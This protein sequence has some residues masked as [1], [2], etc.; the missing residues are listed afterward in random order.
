[1]IYSL[2]WHLQCLK[3]KFLYNL[4]NFK[5]FW[6]SL[7]W[8]L[9]WIIRGL[10]VKFD[11]LYDH[12]RDDPEF[13]DVTLVW[14]K[15][16]QF[17]A[18]HFSILFSKVSQPNP[19]IYLRGQYFFQILWFQMYWITWKICLVKFRCYIFWL[20]DGQSKSS[21]VVAKQF[22]FGK[23]KFGF[24]QPSLSGRING[25][26]PSP[27]RISILWQVIMTNMTII[28]IKTMIDLI[29]ASGHQYHKPPSPGLLDRFHLV[30]QEANQQWGCLRDDRVQYLCEREQNN[31][32]DVAARRCLLNERDL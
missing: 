29:V 28:A 23:I 16:L 15:V 3:Y 24:G 22:S 12:M 8:I 32:K 30:L 13:C 31:F 17:E 19:L 20:F 14:E 27:G 6:A 18:I 4:W 10:P 21:A 9:T 11:T 7:H 5:K 26:H 2:I 1:M 25:V